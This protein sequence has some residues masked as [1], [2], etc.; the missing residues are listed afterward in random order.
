MVYGDS[1]SGHDL[2]VGCVWDSCIP[3][4]PLSAGEPVNSILHAGE[5][6]AAIS[7]E[8]WLALCLLAWAVAVAVGVIIVRWTL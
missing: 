4:S 8:D 6:V 7:D 5:A 1:A 3:A 2:M